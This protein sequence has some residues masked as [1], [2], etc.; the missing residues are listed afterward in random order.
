M[1][2]L[3]SNDLLSKDQHGFRPKRSCDTQLLDSIDSWSRLLEDKTEVEVIY[4]DFRK[5]FDSV[6]HK[7]LIGKLRCYGIGDRVLSWIE[8][9]LEDRMQQVSLYGNL[10]DLVPVRSGVPQGSVLGPLLFLLYVNDLPDAV[11]SNVRMFADDTKLFS[12]ISSEHDV[13]TL[14]ADLNALVEWSRTW[15]LPFN[16]NKCKVLHVGAAKDHHSFQMGSDR[17]TNTSVE[18]DLGVQ[19]DSILKFR[20]Q[21]STAVFKASQVLAVIR[22]SFA[23]LDEF[24]LPLLFKSLV[25]PHLEFSSLVW[26]PFNRADQKAVE[27]VQRRA[28]R[29]VV[30]IRHLPYPERLKRLKL[31]S[32]YYRRRRMDMIHAYKMLHGHV[33]TDPSEL[34]ATN[35]ERRTRGHTLKLRKPRATCRARLNSFSVRCINDW[36]GL[37]AEIV[38]SPS[39]NVF[40]NRLDAHWESIWYST[41]VTD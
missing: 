22:R 27:R 20:Q 37:P 34:L 18:R 23:F 10:S 35:P 26:G 28:T 39:V 36:N 25:R 31:P 12:G 32:L 13:R 3:L 6:P 15:Q 29:L 5:A 11:T 9:F 4:L 14:Q 8:S 40:K 16:E 19:V 21:A 33:D 24:T 30:S 2:H 41:P 1:D 17:L 38:H 7:R